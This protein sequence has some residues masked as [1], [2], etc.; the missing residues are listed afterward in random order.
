MGT[1]GQW[2]CLQHSDDQKYM[3]LLM[4]GAG[5]RQKDPQRS[6][7]SH[8]FIFQTSKTEFKE[9]TDLPKDSGIH[10]G[11]SKS[12]SIKTEVWLPL[13]KVSSAWEWHERGGCKYVWQGKRS[14][15]PPQTLQ[16][17]VEMGVGKV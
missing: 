1:H 2:E 11:S 8:L 7:I 17:Q 4:C 15:R 9:V 3:I 13:G 10:L 12:W 5:K 16:I 6:S 14:S